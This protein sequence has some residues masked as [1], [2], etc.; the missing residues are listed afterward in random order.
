MLG[1]E[2]ADGELNRVVFVVEVQAVD[3]EHRLTGLAAQVP[4]GDSGGAGRADALLRGG[5]GAA[6]ALGLPAD[7]IAVA[8]ALAVPVA[9]GSL[10]AAPGK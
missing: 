3:P 6:V 9:G 1:V 2:V 4:G 7:K 5:D 8:M 10:P